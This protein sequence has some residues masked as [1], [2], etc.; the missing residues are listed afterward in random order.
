MRLLRGW[1]GGSMVKSTCGSCRR[2]RFCCQYPRGISQPG[3]ILVLGE[4]TLSFG[5]DR[6]LHACGTDEVMQAHTHTRGRIKA[7]NMLEM[8]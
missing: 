2:P 6:F 4:P 1:R 7:T 8:C 3:V 5:L